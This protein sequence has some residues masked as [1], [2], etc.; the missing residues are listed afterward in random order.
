MSWLAGPHQDKP[1]TINLHTMNVS[2]VLGKVAPFVAAFVI[3]FLVVFMFFQPLFEGKKLNQGDIMHFQGM[4]KEIA[5]HRAKFGEEP[6][7]TN[8]MFGGMPAY[9]ISTYYPSNLMKKVDQVFRLGLPVPA[10]Y[11]FLYFVGFF[12][13]L[14]VLGINPWVAIAGALAYGLSSYFLIILE[15]G[16]NSKA[17]AIAYMA[18][19]LAGVILTYR[20]KYL[21]GGIIT[22][23]FAALELTANHVQITYY[24]GLILVLLGVAQFIQSILDK[25][26]KQFS[27]ATA[28]LIVAGGL[29]VL[30]NMGNLLTTYEYGKVTI[31]GKSEL[32]HNADV[33]TSGLDKD[34]AT[35]W[36]YGIGETWSLLYPNAKGGASGLIGQD[37]KALDKA[38]PETRPTIAQMNHYWG[39]Q[40]FT[41]GP[42]YIGAIIVFLFVLG[43]MI[44]KGP[45]QWAPLAATL[46]SV[47]LAW[48]HNLMPFTDFFMHYVPG[49]NKFRAVSMT[50]VMAELTMPLLALLTLHKL[51]SEGSPSRYTKQVF[52]AAGIT[53][54]IS[55]LFLASPGSFFNFLSESE[56]LQLGQMQ[57]AGG[58]QAQAAAM[59]IT[60]LSAVREAIFTADVLRS[61]LIILIGVAA[62]LATIYL[63]LN[64]WVAIAIIGV[65][66]FGDLYLVNRRYISDENYVRPT[67]MA[68]PFTPSDADKFIMK[69]TDPDFRVLNLTVSPFMDA[70]TSY[71]HKSIGGY[72]G[73]KL[74]RYQE[75]IDH[76]ISKNNMQVLNMLNTKYLI[77]PGQD[78]QPQVQINMQALGHA[79]FVKELILVDNAD[80]EMA[81]LDSLKTAYQAVVD[82]RFADQVKGFAT[83]VDSTAKIKLESYRANKLVY[84][85]QSSIP[86]LAVFSEIYYDKGWNAYLDGQPVSHFRANYVLRA[87]MVPAGNHTIEFRF[88]PQSYKT[89]GTIA[90]IGS[91]LILGLFLTLIGLEIKKALLSKKSS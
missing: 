22:A 78:R 65:T 2:K 75:L 63:K 36:S 38:A 12:F 7:W 84:K 11:V 9:Q 49:Y 86:Q 44:L 81:A 68:T 46:L 85:T 51:F 89:G 55:L 73:A 47:L 5:D 82:R 21:A 20:G 26:L 8:S 45:L 31:R 24:L 34:Y 91:L 41:S 76:Q 27:I 70:S 23:F 3:F 79:W 53:L 61:M 15:A 52:I 56:Y 35:Q 54:G 60:N 33:K 66:T 16:H 19:V 88:E 40:P 42:V 25:K 64:Q 87:M 29:A 77:V 48:G 69:D 50:L 1:L 28:V 30:P 10:D 71:F 32:S 74:R 72:H 80:Q 17:H 4:S 37:N 90:M 13:L 57:Q 6:L 18:P 43:F 59:Y 14:I 62:I 58:E 83:G 67:K 39:D